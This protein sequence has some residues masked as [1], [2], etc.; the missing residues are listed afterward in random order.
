LAA[1]AATAAAAPDAPFNAAEALTYEKN[2]HRTQQ[3]QQ[4][5]KVATS[6]MGAAPP[7]YYDSNITTAAVEH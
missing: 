5:S 3:Q 4:Q 2:K 1:D 6:S 7:R